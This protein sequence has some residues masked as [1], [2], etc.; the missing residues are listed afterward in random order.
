MDEKND[1]TL[2]SQ[3]EVNPEL[4]FALSLCRDLDLP[5]FNLS[6]YRIPPEVLWFIPE[7]IA[8][9]FNIIPLARFG[10]VFTIAVSNP[11]DIVAFDTLRNIASL[12]LQIVISTP[13]QIK[14]AIEENYTAFKTEEAVVEQADIIEAAAT[15]TGKETKPAGEVF[16]IEDAVELSHKTQIVE[17]VNNILIEALK[18]RAS[19]I[20]IEPYPDILRIRYR[21]DGV[22]QER[23]P[24]IEKKYE[25]ALIARLKIMSKLDITQ[26]RLPQDG[27]ISIRL[28]AKDIDLRVS[29]LPLSTG[30]KVVLRILEKGSLQLDLEKLGFSEYSLNAFKEA[31]AR[32]HGMII[33]TGPTGSG[34]STTLYAILNRLNNMEKNIITIEDPVE[35]Q[36]KGITQIQVK[37]EIGLTF[38]N[39]L[40]AVLRQNPDI[41]MVGEMRDFETADIAIKAALT[42]HLIL[43]TLHTN[44]APTAIV[45]LMNMGIEPFLIASTLSLVAA[46]RLCR[47][48]CPECKQPYEIPVANLSG[49]PKGF[50]EPKARFWR[51][52]GCKNC[53]NTG[54]FGRVA[55]VEALMLDDTIRK[56]VL[57]KVSIS[58][59]R[60][61]A[62]QKGMKSLREDAMHKALS[63]EISLEEVLR[64]TPEE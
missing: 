60:E 34:K 54:Y 10:L 1:Y 21:I 46:Q 32:P 36:M 8:R 35:Y 40:R 17:M 15:E 4:D 44:D 56:M 5:F 62:S 43:S 59:I 7:D 45:R 16:E 58:K 61:Y 63:G 33:I 48:I 29:V 26:K 51:G 49:L 50:K 52:K 9:H 14:R 31:S 20:H 2:K 64:V 53:N 6:H 47:K 25:R 37:T 42:G 22:L 12:I 19:D 3:S 30:E 39:V 27:R 28:G 55:V 11:Y 18:Q 41:V 23:Q 13:S 57:E 24:Q 38:A